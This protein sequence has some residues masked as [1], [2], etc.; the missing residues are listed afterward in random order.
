MLKDV[1]KAAALVGGLLVPGIAAAATSAVVTTDLNIR[2]GPGSGYQRFGTIPAGYEVTVYGCLSGYNWC[3]VNFGGD[4]GW[5][6]GKYLAYLGERYYRRP[7]S[8]VGVSIGL[9][10]VGFEPYDYHR[11]YYVGRPWYRDRYLDRPRYRDDGPW[12]RDRDR[13]ARERD[14]DRWERDRDRDRGR[15]ERERDRRENARDRDRDRGRD[16]VERP[17]DR[18]RDR[19]RGR[20]RGR[21]RDRPVWVQPPNDRN[22]EPGLR[23]SR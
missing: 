14:R 11:R 12:D 13:W 1:L 19:D 21:D 4:R 3:D 17:R 6:S 16:V 8:S 10:I 18:D 20:D 9:P 7:I 15:W 2:T 23:G 5:V 22:P